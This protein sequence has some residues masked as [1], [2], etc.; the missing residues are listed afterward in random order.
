MKVF[1]SEF[2][3]VYFP[4]RV[5][6]NTHPARILFS[7]SY[8]SI[9]P[10]LSV[11]SSI[12]IF[13][14]ISLFLSLYLSMTEHASQKLFS[15]RT[16]PLTLPVNVLAVYICVYTRIICAHQKQGFN[17]SRSQRHI[18]HTFILNKYQTRY[19]IVLILIIYLVALYL[20]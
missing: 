11:C 6:A 9:F 16:P 8:L 17:D 14:F 10:F 13:I 4:R 20:V 1:S 19:G 18:T 2:P 3:G 15:C 12:F 7:L 5:Y